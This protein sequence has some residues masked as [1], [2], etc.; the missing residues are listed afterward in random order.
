MVREGGEEGEMNEAYANE[1]V[2][3]MSRQKQMRMRRGRKL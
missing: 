3:E 1:A 2:Q